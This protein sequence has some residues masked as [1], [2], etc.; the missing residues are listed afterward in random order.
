MKLPCPGGDGAVHSRVVASQG[1]S[2]STLRPFQMLWKKLM[3]KGICARPMTQAAIEIGVFHWKPVNP[4][5]CSA[6]T[7]QPWP[8]SYQRRCIP[9]IPCKNIGR[10]ITFM[11]ISDG[12]K[13]TLPQNSFRSEERRVGKECRVRW[14]T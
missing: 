13:C 2:F 4:Q 8:P 10:K 9:S 1:L 7:F 5:M 12:Q 3:M 6:E 11:Q 14:G